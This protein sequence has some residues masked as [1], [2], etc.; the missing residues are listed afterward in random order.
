MK[1]RF[2]LC[3]SLD[4]LDA[5]PTLLDV[6]KEAGVD[7]IWLAGFL[8]GYWHYPIDRLVQWRSMIEKKGMVAHVVNVPLGHPGDA[9]GAMHGDV[10]ITPPTHWKT[11][12]RPDGSQ[13]AGT[14][15]H[16]PACEE[17]VQALRLL[18]SHGFREAFL[19]DDYRVAQ[20]P[21]TVGGCFCSEHRERFLKRYGYRDA[22]WQGL[23]NDVRQRRLSA[24]LRQWCDFHCDELTTCYRQMQR[25]APRTRLR[26]MV[27][28][29]GAEK[30]GIR[31]RDYD[32][33]GFRVGEEHFNDGSFGSLKGKTN[34]LFS[35]LF[36]RRFVAPD[37]AYSETTAYPA[38]AL[39]AQNMAAKLVISTLADIRHTM[40]MS[41][42]S[43]F[44][45]E[46]WQTLAP[47]MRQQAELHE[48]I[49]GQRPS[50][51]LKHFW[52]EAG[53]YVG[54]DN[55]YSLFLAIGVPFEV[56]EAPPK[57]GWVFLGDQDARELPASVWRGSRAVRIARPHAAQDRHTRAVPEELDALFALKREIVSALRDVPYVEEE[58]PVVCAW[59]PKIRTVALWNLLER[60]Q[61]LTVRLN[62][63]RTRVR[64]RPL[65]LALVRLEDA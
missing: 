4:A 65:E 30:A 8:Y 49:A 18:T 22:D 42:L 46:H 51:P 16:P 31:L 9:L 36:H 41:G 20:S 57:E 52:G 43:P 14:S 63:Q 2:H 11:G 25:A 27:M 15:L 23:L 62:E 37:R 13:Y 26:V 35:V 1:R 59:Y 19:D 33:A 39:S 54:D 17:N 28:Y 61:V 38:T 55:P 48:Q 21:G 34:E 3:L 10:P 60:Q 53:R 58:T 7:T 5:D 32:D 64:M 44:P 40:Y 12:V 50:G 24:I 29:M 56:A 45:R 6:V 47:A